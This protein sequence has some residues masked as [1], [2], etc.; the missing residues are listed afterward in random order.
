MIIQ[1][2][3]RAL[4][5]GLRW[6]P[7]IG[8]QPAGAK[9][10]EMGAS[11]FW[12]DAAGE[13][14]GGVPAG[15]SL[16]KKGPV[17]CAAQAVV[18]A[19]PGGGNVLAVFRLPEPHDGYAIVGLI[20]GRPRSGF[21]RDHVD[22]DGLE[23]VLGNFLAIAGDE[24]FQL[25]GDAPLQDIQPLT[26]EAVAAAADDACLLRRVPH[27]IRPAGVL[28]AA[29]V[30]VAVG[31]GLKYYQHYRDHQRAL[32]RERA[33]KSP[34]QLYAEAM[35]AAA[36]VPVAKVTDLDDW[37]SWTVSLPRQIGGWNFTESDCAAAPERQKLVCTL[38]FKRGTLPLVTNQTFVDAA[39]RDWP[40]TAITFDPSGK[41]IQVALERDIHTQPTGSI[42]DALPD[43]RS[44]ELQF[45][46]QLQ[47]LERVA[48]GNGSFYGDYQVFGL[49]SGVSPGD[50]PSP[51]F[52]AKWSFGGPA[53]DIGAVRLFPAYLSV[54]HVKFSWSE[55][56]AQH[57]LD[58][59]IGSIDVS[60]QLFA[61]K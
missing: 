22:E 11:W 59:S 7:I 20:R 25:V 27:R 43:A 53:R 30:L 37:F 57:D 10:R 39:P 38:K 9:A 41:F 52:S 60:G 28:L 44:V 2:S 55:S 33:E 21:D 13:L 61:K 4:A 19:C 51:V 49:P 3:G 42:L 18:R 50:I 45:H 54:E 12:S 56:E 24:A 48:K 46:S 6:Q 14:V 16:P 34:A 58:S 32:E 47:R 8:G 29:L 35:A 1:S 40:A 26:L 36:Q 5:F 15:D 17:Y 31:G 23:E